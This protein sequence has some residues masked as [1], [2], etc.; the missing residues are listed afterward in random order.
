MATLGLAEHGPEG[1]DGP[2]DRLARDLAGLVEALA[3]A[4]DLGPIHDGGPRAVRPAL[5]QV[6]LDRARAAVDHRVPG[7]DAVDEL[8]EAA[9][10][11]GVHPAGQPEALH[12]RPHG[13]GVLAFDGQRAGGPAAGVDVGELRRPVLATEAH[14]P[15]VD[16]HGAPG[17]ARLDELG[18]ELLERVVRA[19]ER[20]RGCA[21]RLEGG[22]DLGG[23]HREGGVEHGLPP[24]EA[25]GVDLPEQLEVEAALPDL[26]VVRHRPR[27]VVL[28]LGPQQVE[29]VAL[30]GA[31][32]L[33]PGGGA[34]GRPEG[35]AEGPPLPAG[36]RR[37][38]R[39]SQQGASAAWGP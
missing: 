3:Q 5:R 16:G 33:E 15:L 10:E 4:G 35:P 20:G 14:P 22:G 31:A 26:D 21:R 9:G 27:G 2:F 36:G 13:S 11:A 30:L 32:G 25:D 1:G 7:G 39:A 24:L 23:G 12:G 38:H 6:E 18:E 37:R 19:A 29:L 28:R 8:G 34:A 17:G